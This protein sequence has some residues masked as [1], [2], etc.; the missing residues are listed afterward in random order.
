MIFLLLLFPLLMFYS[1]DPD[2]KQSEEVIISVRGLNTNVP[3]QWPLKTYSH[4]S[5]FRMQLIYACSFLKLSP[6]HALEV[7]L[8]D[9]WDIQPI[10]KFMVTEYKQEIHFGH[11]YCDERVLPRSLIDFKHNATGINLRFCGKCSDP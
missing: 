10:F 8:L 11:I 3:S 7:T 6:V 2:L 1:Q 4:F 5:L 9:H